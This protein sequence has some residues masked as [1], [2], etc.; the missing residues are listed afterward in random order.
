MSLNR[1]FGTFFAGAVMALVLS[2]FSG[3]AHARPSM[4]DFSSKEWER[5]LAEMDA[6]DFDRVMYAHNVAVGPRSS[7]AEQLKY[8]RDLRAAVLAELKRGTPFMQVRR[9]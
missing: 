2:L 8:L 9:R 5:T 1:L 6:L 7:V 3:R 4:P